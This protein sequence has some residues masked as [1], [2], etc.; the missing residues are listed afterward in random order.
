MA[1][2]DAWLASWTF[3]GSPLL[4]QGEP[5]ARS[6]AGGGNKLETNGGF[7]PG[8]SEGLALKR[9]LRVDVFP[10]KLKRSSHSTVIQEEVIYVAISRGP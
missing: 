9:N 2:P 3:G 1:C 4:Q 7:S 5:P 8:N 10:G 6:V